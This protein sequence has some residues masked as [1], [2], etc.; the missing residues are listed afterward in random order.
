MHNQDVLVDLEK[1]DCLLTREDNGIDVNSVTGHASI[2]R[3]GSWDDLVSLK[4]DR[5]HHISC[6]S[7]HC[8]DSI[9][10]NGGSMSSEGEMKRARIERMKSLKKMKNSKPASSIGNLVA[11]II[12]VIF[13]CFILWQGIPTGNL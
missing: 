10:K 4:D 8:R 3:E 2:M 6:C 5:S 11:L 13:C 9:A 7:S 1:G 12:T